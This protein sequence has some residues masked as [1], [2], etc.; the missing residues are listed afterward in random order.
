MKVRQTLQETISPMYRQGQIFQLELNLTFFLMCIFSPYFAIQLTSTEIVYCTF[1]RLLHNSQTTYLT[2][3]HTTP[4]SSISHL[5]TLAAT[6]ATNPAPRHIL[7]LFNTF[8][9]SRSLEI[10]SACVVALLTESPMFLSAQERHNTGRHN[11]KRSRP[12]KGVEQLENVPW[13]CV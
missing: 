11:F 10:V 7:K 8:P 1:L 3:H 6:Q 5:F 2:P 12:W 4:H 9:W 13:S